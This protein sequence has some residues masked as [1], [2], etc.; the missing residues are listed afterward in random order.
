MALTG[1]HPVAQKGRGRVYRIAASNG[2]H[3][4]SPRLCRGMVTLACHYH[5][6]LDTIVDIEA[7]P[8][9]P[10]PAQRIDMGRHQFEIALRKLLIGLERQRIMSPVQ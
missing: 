8:I 6:L 5:G 9:A 7:I 3:F 2:S 10:R 1:H 4:E